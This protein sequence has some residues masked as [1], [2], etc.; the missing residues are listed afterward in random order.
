M[1]FPKEYRKVGFKFPILEL[2]VK[3]GLLR[4]LVGSVMSALHVSNFDSSSVVWL[5]QTTFLEIDN[6]KSISPFAL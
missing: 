4:Y 6:H 3:R 5:T 1:I 2:D